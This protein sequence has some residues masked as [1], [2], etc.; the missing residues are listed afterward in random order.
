MGKKKNNRRA[1]WWRH[2]DQVPAEY[3]LRKKKE[4]KATRCNLL[5]RAGVFLESDGAWWKWPTDG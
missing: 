5:L 1:Q 2:G 3:V 4:V